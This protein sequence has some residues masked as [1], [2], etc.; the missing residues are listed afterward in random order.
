LRFFAAKERKDL[1]VLGVAECAVEF[2]A[3]TGGLLDCDNGG[4]V[5]HRLALP[6]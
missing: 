3:D 4:M 1:P 5:H 6:S 2:T